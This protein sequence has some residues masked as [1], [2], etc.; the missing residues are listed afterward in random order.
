M[1]N[2]NKDLNISKK[3]WEGLKPDQRKRMLELFNKSPAQ[4]KRTRRIGSREGG[5]SQEEG[6]KVASLLAEKTKRRNERL[7]QEALKKHRKEVAAEI[8]EDER[9]ETIGSRMGGRSQR[10][11][12]TVGNR[13]KFFKF[14]EKNKLKK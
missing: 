9:T 4:K 7:R 14:H 11:G 8:K 10:E 5:R 3:A 2:W 6:Q 12:R 1:S 13:I